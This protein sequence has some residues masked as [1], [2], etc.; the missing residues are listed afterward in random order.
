MSTGSVSGFCLVAWLAI[1]AAA[2]WIGRSTAAVKL[3]RFLEAWSYSGQ[4]AVVQARLLAADDPRRQ[5]ILLR[6]AR[7]LV[8]GG[9]EILAIQKLAADEAAK[10]GVSRQER[11]A[12]QRA[13]R[14]VGLVVQS[15]ARYAQEVASLLDPVAHQQQIQAL[16]EFAGVEKAAPMSA[17]VKNAGV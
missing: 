5:D 10:E 1:L 16:R 7:Q 6:R 13:A 14:K 8:T 2:K 4:I 17:R 9:G 15:H 11:E 3:R 12:I